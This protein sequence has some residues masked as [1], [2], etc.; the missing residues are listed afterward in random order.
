MRQFAAAILEKV[1][2]RRKNA[3]V[4]AANDY[5]AP[6]IIAKAQRAGIL[7]GAA[8]ALISYN[9]IAFAQLLPVPLTSVQLPFGQLAE[10]A[11][12]MLLDPGKTLLR[13]P[14]TSA[15]LLE[16]RCSSVG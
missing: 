1:W 6:G 9:D 5:L 13:H 2:N 10:S 4:L 14:R 15:L 7:I 3:A 16:T 11:L 8:I 12:R